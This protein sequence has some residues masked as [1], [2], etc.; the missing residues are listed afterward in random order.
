MESLFMDHVPESWTKLAYPSL[1]GLAAWFSDL[2]LRLTELEN[3]SGDFNVSLF[4]IVVTVVHCVFSITSTL[5][6][7]T[8][9]N[10][11]VL[12]VAV[13]S[14]DRRENWYFFLEDSDQAN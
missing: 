3:W 9:Y 14:T 11:G 12:Y 13:K 1:L 7:S 4:Y 5:T 6:F 8:T 10:I 2:C